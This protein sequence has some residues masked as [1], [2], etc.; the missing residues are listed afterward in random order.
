VCIHVVIENRQDTNEHNA[1]I[2]KTINGSVTYFDEAVVVEEA[3]HGGSGG[4]EVPVPGGGDVADDLVD[5]GARLGVEVQ[6]QPVPLRRA[7]A[8]EDRGR[9]RHGQRL[10]L[11]ATRRADEGRRRDEQQ[12]EQHAA[13]DEEA[14][15]A[16]RGIHWF[17]CAMQLQCRGSAAWKHQGD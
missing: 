7:P 9:R 8:A 14:D 13:V 2:Y 10:R 15:G 11:P 1:M 12:Q 3:E 5:R 16:S 6:R 4:G 17:R